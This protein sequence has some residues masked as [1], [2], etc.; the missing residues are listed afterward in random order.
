MAE[1]PSDEGGIENPTISGHEIQAVTDGE[2]ENLLGATIVYV[3]GPDFTVDRGWLEGRAGELGIA[4][5]VLPSET[6]PKRAFTRAADRVTDYSLGDARHPDVSVETTRQDYNTFEFELIDRRPDDS[7]THEIVGE[8]EYVDGSPVHQT[9]TEEAD[10]VE[11][12]AKYAS[13]FQDEWEL[14]KESNTGGDIRR[15]IREFIKRPDTAGVKMRDAGAVYFVPRSSLDEMLKL[16]ELVEE[17]NT[18]WKTSGFEAAVDTIEVIDSAD[19]RDMVER[20]VRRTMDDIVESALDAAFDELDE[21]TAAQDV[22]SEVGADLVRAENV[23]VE[24]NALLDVELSVEE[25]LESWKD[26]V[27]GEQKEELVEAAM[28]EVDV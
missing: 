22:V 5:D 23:A 6:S 26:D 21:E 17:I 8:F 12:F 19:K 28:G 3:I 9:R 14:Q 27:S 15:M 11:T 10:Y 2:V 16:K 20:K 13:Q 24:H 1:D 4:P 7:V 18:S 25:V